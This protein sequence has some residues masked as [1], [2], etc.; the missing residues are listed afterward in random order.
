MKK[1]YAKTNRDSLLR[2]IS[3][4]PAE[5]FDGHTDFAKLTPRERLLWLSNTNYLI[6]KMSKN[7]PQLGCTAFFKKI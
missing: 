5:Y 4:C 2:K 1:T 7:N 6:F 3:E